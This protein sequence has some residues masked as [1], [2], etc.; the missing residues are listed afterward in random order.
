MSIGG[1]RRCKEM[2]LGGGRYF[3]SHSTKISSNSSMISSNMT[4]RSCMGKK[5]TCSTMISSGPR[6]IRFRGEVAGFKINRFRGMMAGFGKDRLRGA[7]VGGFEK[8]TWSP[9]ISIE[10]SKEEE[11]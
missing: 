3:S 4:S 1:R 11:E 7:T 10:G 5:R 9:P 6:L 8:D 2:S